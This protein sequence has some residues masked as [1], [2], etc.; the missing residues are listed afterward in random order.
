M[1]PRKPKQTRKKGGKVLAA[2][3]D[4]CVFSTSAW[5]CVDGTAPAGYNPEDPS[6][7]TKMISNQDNEYD[8]MKLATDILGGDSPSILKTLGTCQPLLNE[9]NVMVKENKESL[10]LF[11]KE[12]KTRNAC[13]T[14]AFKIPTYTVNGNSNNENPTN[15]TQTNKNNSMNKFKLLI[16]KKYQTTLRQFIQT[17][18]SHSQ[19]IQLIA[20]FN[21]FLV[22][23]KK[24][25][26]NPT[27]VL[28]NV[29]LHA[30]NIYINVRSG[31]GIDVGMA[32]FG[33]CAIKNDINNP[34]KTWY[35]YFANYLRN[36]NLVCNYY[37]IGF[38]ARLINFSLMKRATWSKDDIKE[39]IVMC[40]T[41]ISCLDYI[42][43]KFDINPTYFN[44]Q[45][46][47][48]IYQ[49]EH[50]NPTQVPEQAIND[51]ASNINEIYKIIPG[52]LLNS[53]VKSLSVAHQFTQESDPLY[54]SRSS[55][56]KQTRQNFA[57]FFSK[58][59][60]WNYV[61]DLFNGLG[62]YIYSDK[63]DKIITSPGLSQV[64]D[65]VIYRH[66]TIGIMGVLLQELI[67]NYFAP[68]DVRSESKLI[69]QYLETGN[70]S[71]W[72]R[73]APDPI[74]PDR[75]ILR[76]M[77]HQYYDELI[78][79]YTD[80]N[81]FAFNIHNET[82]LPAPQFGFPDWFVPTSLFISPNIS[83]N[84][85]ATPT[86]ASIQSKKLSIFPKSK[87]SNIL[88]KPIT[89]NHSGGRRKT[90]RSVRR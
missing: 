12:S 29:D 67:I 85:S 88:G 81:T 51:L 24:L 22:D 41:N 38:E 13:K 56:T 62:L 19:L 26:Q 52:E 76:T 74:T 63:L 18:L 83:P 57:T 82:S 66:H 39:A 37:Q 80:K 50:S 34:N 2:G 31:S 78:R 7:V 68:D 59:P 65:F 45:T 71:K 58:F 5:P 10:D 53:Y 8:T 17:K 33:R 42:T 86:T 16:N 32:D 79:P 60:H 69:G 6:V 48:L 44:Q 55:K 21:R 27:K 47:D 84:M 3:Q 9:T 77:L 28:V 70:I 40:P 87:V 14:I 30:E 54:L 1:S 46:M 36:S 35:T 25:I 73:D 90:R 72:P 15:P 49:I 4:G 89:S 11:A 64:F 43:D 20:G 23:C 75:S 61:T